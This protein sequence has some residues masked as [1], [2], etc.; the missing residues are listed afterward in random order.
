MGE[1]DGVQLFPAAAGDVGRPPGGYP[2]PVDD[3]PV[4]VTEGGE[5]GPDLVL[6]DAGEGRRTW[7]IPRRHRAAS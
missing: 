7:E 5:L 2:L 6:H 3:K 4:E 1:A